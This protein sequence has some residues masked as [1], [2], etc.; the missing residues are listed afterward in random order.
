[1]VGIFREVQGITI[2]LEELIKREFGTG[3]YVMVAHVTCRVKV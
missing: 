1:M 3:S 2:L